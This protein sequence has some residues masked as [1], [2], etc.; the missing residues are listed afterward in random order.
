MSAGTGTEPNFG[1]L[2]ARI[3]GKLIINKTFLFV[4]YNMETAMYQ[5]IVK[6][7]NLGRSK[8]L[9]VKIFLFKSEESLG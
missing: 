5:E 8:H 4:K 7:V 2:L 3:D 6:L 9:Q 1:R